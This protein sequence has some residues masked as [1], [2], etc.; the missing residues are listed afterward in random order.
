LGYTPKN[1]CVLVS[2]K[3]IVF[4]FYVSPETS[5]PSMLLPGFPEQ[6]HDDAAGQVPPTFMLFKER[7]GAPAS[8]QRGQA[9]NAINTS[10][11]AH[12]YR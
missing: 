9:R 1:N 2:S 10:G 12:L 3:S 11:A 8:S 6:K 7:V 5:W 4:L